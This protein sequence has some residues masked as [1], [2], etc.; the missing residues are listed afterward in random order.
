MGTGDACDDCGGV[1]SI[2]SVFGYI[3]IISGAGGEG[4]GRVFGQESR[5]AR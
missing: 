3:D 2:V 1:A 5:R 4:F